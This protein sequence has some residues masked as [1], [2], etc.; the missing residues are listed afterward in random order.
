MEIF[1]LIL[2]LLLSA[3]FSSSETAFFHL[4][5]SNKD[6]PHKVK[7]FLKNP[8]KLLVSL[9]VGNTIVN[10]LIAFLATYFTI[11]WANKNNFNQS[12]ALLFEII[13]ITI[14]ILIFGE[15]IPKTIAIK[16]SSNI[17]SI[18]S[19]SLSYFIVVLKPITFLFSAITTFFL[20][21]LPNKTEKIFDSEEELKI[22]AEI[23]E[24]EGTLQEDE[25]DIIQSIFEF[26]NKTVGEI[27]TPRVDMI[28][29]ESN[30]SIDEA[31]DIISEKQFSKI[32][33]YKNNIDNISGILYAKDIIPYLT[34]SRQN[35]NL[36][37]IS[38]TPLFVPE[39]KP[40]NE[41]LEDF[42]GKKTN[43]AIIVD[44]W[45]GTEGLIT[46][47]DLVEEVIGEIR[48]PFDKEEIPIIKQS[49]DV[50]IANASITIYDLQEE[51]EI[52]FPD[53]R[54]YDTLGGF[55]LDSMT[56]IPKK[57]EYVNYKKW[58]FEVNSIN[59]NRIEKVLIKKRKNDFK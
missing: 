29:L 25:S 57:G 23:G 36:L 1:L 35:I 33:I 16:K 19:K 21:L 45:G 55:I 37:S 17:A 10:V 39:T 56:Y 58:R 52:I 13:I 5:S 18:F 28:A 2:L 26:D 50:F 12:K 53:E 4:R 14:L 3:Y 49:K 31:M 54:D 20:Q 51:T 46:L 41:L 22:L 59:N 40:I 32:P 48:D 34:G 24:E 44:E 15:I 30:A 9:L 6:V 7:K 38:R 27:I 47:E 42:K 11:S 8:Q 43:I